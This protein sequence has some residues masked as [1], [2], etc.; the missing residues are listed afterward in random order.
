MVTVPSAGAVHRLEKESLTRQI[1]YR[2]HRNKA[3]AVSII[4]GSRYQQVMA[5]I[6]S[7]ERACPP[8]WPRV[9]PDIPLGTLCLT[10]GCEELQVYSKE[11]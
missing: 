3:T 5:R 4:V 2:A 6:R 7:H 8:R 10:K 11:L 1:A 9:A